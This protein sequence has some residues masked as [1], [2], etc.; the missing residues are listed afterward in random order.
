V[1][2]DVQAGKIQNI[3][4]QKGGKFLQTVDVFDVF[5]SDSLGDGKKSIAYT[6]RFNSPD[7]TLVD[8]EVD[9]AISSICTGVE[10]AFNAELRK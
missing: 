3:I 2:D 6:L 9:K 10:K 1:D 8:K 5:E 4:V 7:K